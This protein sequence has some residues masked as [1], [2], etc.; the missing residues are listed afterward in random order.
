[1]LSSEQK[2]MLRDKVCALLWDVGMKVE[3][4]ALSGAMRKQGC[5]EAPTGRLRI[6][7]KLID[8]MALVQRTSQA[9]DREDQRLHFRC[10]IDW[11]HHILWNRQQERTADRLQSEFLMPAFDCGPTTYYD[12]PSRAPRAIDTEILVEMMRFA[13]STPEIGY[14]S[15]WYRQ[16]VPPQIERIESLVMA[17]KH[18]DKVDGIEAID[19]EVIKYLKEISEIVTGR[20][21]DASYLAGSEC[22]TSPMILE[23]R[24]AADIVERSRRGI[25]RYHVASMPTIGISTPVT[26]AGSI[27][28]T[29]AEILGGMVACFV[30]DPDSD[31]SGRAIALV[32]DM[33]NANNTP[34]GPEPTWVN[35]AVREIFEAF[36]GG[37]LWVEVFFSP[38]AQRPGLQAVYE[39]FYGQWRYSR[40]LGDPDIPYPGM[41][42]LHSGGMGSPA[43]FMLDMEIRKS[44]FALNAEIDTGDD[45]VAFEEACEV[46]REDK[47]FLSHEHTLAHYRSLWSS[48]VFLNQTPEAASWSGDEKAILDTCDQMW[49]ENLKDYRPPEW[50]AETTRAL[51][52]V[53]ARAKKE[54][55]IP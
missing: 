36:W 13:Q 11:A 52:E 49:R 42:T 12:Y 7:R 46:A 45:M 37:H 32:A 35:L 20:P 6:P 10:G 18:T 29:A 38:Y 39:N 25:K 9:E 50:P 27:M 17:L 2:E 47:N 54:F 33:R 44:Q 4:D 30:M 51:D 28:M 1:M 40:L 19:P 41:G 34:T 43:Q 24:S 3:N 22:I 5:Q 31:L 21:G 48:T 55:G 14:I 53:L 26:V 8:E 16:D 15:T 23:R